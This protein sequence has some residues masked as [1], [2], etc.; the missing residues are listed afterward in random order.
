MS[1]TLIPSLITPGKHFSVGVYKPQRGPAYAFTTEGEVT[2]REDGSVQSFGYVLFEARTHRV[3][4]TGNNTKGN[5]ITALKSL[6]NDMVNNGWISK[7]DGI[8]NMDKDLT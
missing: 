2:R 8:A 1:K 6:L 3:P 7:E 4:L 5:R